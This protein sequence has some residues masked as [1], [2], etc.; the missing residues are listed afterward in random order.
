MKSTPA[1]SVAGGDPLASD[2]QRLL[3][4]GGIVL[5]VVGLVFGDLF[6]VFVLHPNNA[7][8]GEALYT[9]A[10]LIPVGDNAGIQAQ[11]ATIGS[12]LENRGTKVDTHSHII[13][14][15][16]IA[17]L[18]ALLHPWVALSSALKRGATYVFI[19]GAIL[20]P[21]SIFAIHYVGLSASPLEHIGWA[22]MLADLSG[23]LLALAVFLH[24]YGLWRHAREA[25]QIDGDTSCHIAIDDGAARALLLGGLVLLVCGFLYGAAYAAAQRF[26][27][28]SSEVD[29]LNNI[30]A[31]AAAVQTDLL[32]QDFAALARFQMLRAINIAVHTHINELGILLL[33]MAFLQGHIQFRDATRRFWA[34]S[35]LVSAFALPLG[36]LLEIPAGIL[37][38][39]IADLAGL[40]LIVSLIAML[41]GLLRTTGARDAR[42]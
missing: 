7:R 32:D 13:H 33:L 21:P 14:V 19:V 22:S 42:A 41:F 30:V 25:P 26:G 17:L 36:V 8:I 20:M 15:G 9:A 24:F 29:I 5:V 34:R 23:A 31:H 37:G 2:P 12:L 10:E 39:V 35:A 11:F 40:G 27:L 38:R 18:L 28:G 16:Y 6:A 1:M 3:A 4:I